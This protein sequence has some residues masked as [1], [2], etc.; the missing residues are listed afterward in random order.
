MKTYKVLTIRQ[1]WAELIIM[2]IKPIEN[3]S[4][5]TE[6]RGPLLIHA[7]QAYEGTPDIEHKYGIDPDALDYGAIIGRVDLIDIV[8]EHASEF[9]VGPYGW[10]LRNPRRMSPIP[11]RGQQRLFNAKLTPRYI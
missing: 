3:R 11:A 6:H 4:W 1:P 7:G 9:F 2:G 5:K 8:T 10:V